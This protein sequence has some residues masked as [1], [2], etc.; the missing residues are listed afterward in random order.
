[1]LIAFDIDGTLADLTH[2]LHYIGG[3]DHLGN[4]MPKDWDAFHQTCD[5]DKPIHEIVNL[6]NEL[7][8]GGNDVI[9]V[10]GR[11]GIVRT[12][13]V[14]WLNDWIRLSSAGINAR[15]YMRDSKDHRP[16]YIIKTELLVKII[17][18][19]G[20]KPNIVFDDRQQVVEMW[21][22]QGIR[23]CQVAPGNF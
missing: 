19:Y 11:N 9:F 7:I 10:S 5:K 18:D 20:Q 3:L 12:K 17:K 13:T 6:C 15:L 16:D 23:T 14:E 2:R 1:M 22:G 4:K 21:R 8:V